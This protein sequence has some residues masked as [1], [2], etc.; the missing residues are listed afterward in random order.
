MNKEISLLK[1]DLQNPITEFL[2]FLKFITDKLYEKCNIA[3]SLIIIR[4]NVKKKDKMIT[5]WFNVLFHLH[6][7]SLGLE[8]LQF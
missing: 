7:F 4:K 2:F 5:T 3:I 8:Y 6:I 1:C